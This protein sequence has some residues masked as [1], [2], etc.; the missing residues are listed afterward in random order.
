VSE[1]EPELPEVE[2]EHVLMCEKCGN[3]LGFVIYFTKTSDLCPTCH[4]QAEPSSCWLLCKKC[5]GVSN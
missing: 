2:E 3:E 1:T 4:N 5:R